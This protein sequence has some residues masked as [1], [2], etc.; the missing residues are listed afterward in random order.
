MNSDFK[1]RRAPMLIAS[2]MLVL[3][4]LMVIS[5]ASSA[6]EINILP[7]SGPYRELDADTSQVFEWV[8]YNNGSE[9][10]VVKGT[11]DPVSYNGVTAE[12]EDDF[13][14]LGPMESASMVVTFTAGREVSDFKKTFLVNFTATDMSSPSNVT[15]NTVEVE[16][17][18]VSIFG[19]DAGANK[20]LHIWDNN[21]PEP[22]NT[23]TGAFLVSVLIWLGIGFAFYFI[24]DPTVHLLTRKTETELDDIILHI[25]RMPLF[26]LI[27]L[28]GSVSS[29]EILDISQKM[30]A[31]IEMLYAIAL[32]LIGAWLAYKIYDE[33]VLYYAKKFAKKTETELDDVLIPV[34]EKIGMIVFPFLA[35]MLIFQILGYDLTV[36][37]AGAGFLGLVVGLA[38]Q[39][40]L[41]NFFAGIQ[42]LIDRPFKIGD[43][44]MLES[45]DFAEVKHI[46]L[47][48]TEL[49]DTTNNQLI[50]IP[51]DQMA[52]N[53]IVNAV[54]P[55]RGLTIAVSIGVAY[56]S[57]I[58]LVKKLMLEAFSEM[59]NSNKEKVP[60][61]R[62][63]DF[64]DSSINMKIF[65]PIDAAP[66]KWRAASEFREIL[67]RKFK[68]NKVEIPFPQR[69]VYLKTEG[70]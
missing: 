57:D 7:Q 22:L 59:A 39:S 13:I 51:N 50:V 14:T 3:L 34:L 45:G 40:T 9:P 68:E 44:L 16:L 63:S 20:I 66:N 70:K 26:L 27:V 4:V 37:L 29:I 69:V 38:A 65:I 21:L 23:N 47:R 18:V 25:L 8:I 64:A 11:V 2:L 35:L 30:V 15:V 24:V 41:A 12:F 6:G 5:P 52:N 19:V 43:L 61:I 58:E 48:A 55:D 46:G 56:G 60:A 1:V 31:D 67:Y 62:L 10:V 49:L 32:V 42:L 36:L 17:D 33:I 53:K 54:M 28:I